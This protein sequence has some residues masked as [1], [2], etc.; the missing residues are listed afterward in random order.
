VGPALQSANTRNPGG[1]ADSLECKPTIDGLLRLGPPNEDRQY[2][3]NSRESEEGN[4]GHEEVSSVRS[5]ENHS[6][7]RAAET[8]SVN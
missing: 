4:L 3:E 1:Q 7:V 2:R 8:M 6:D 5:A